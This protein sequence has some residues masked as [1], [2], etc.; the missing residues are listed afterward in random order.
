MTPS[1]YHRVRDTWLS[2][3]CVTLLT[4][5][6]LW[7]NENIMVY[8]H[9]I[10]THNVTWSEETVLL[11]RCRWV[12]V[13]T[14][15]PNDFKFSVPLYSHTLLF[16]PCQVSLF[17]SRDTTCSFN[18]IQILHILSC[19]FVCS[20]VRISETHSILLIFLQMLEER[21]AIEHVHYRPSS[22]AH[23]DCYTSHHVYVSRHWHNFLAWKKRE[24]IKPS[25]NILSNIYHRSNF[26]HRS[27]SWFVCWLIVSWGIRVCLPSQTRLH[28][29]RHCVQVF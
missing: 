27:L 24:N 15:C 7:L 8:T 20:H 2:I 21:F 14:L 16:P 3:V 29:F 11:D 12:Y 28:F 18:G 23:H 4:I 5:V 17:T 22:L 10:L 25:V 13:V 1:S 19:V 26:F 9:F 6:C